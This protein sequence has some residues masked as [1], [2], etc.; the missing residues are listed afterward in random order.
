MT[1]AAAYFERKAPGYL[2]ACGRGLWGRL[3]AAE[4][5]AVRACLE[6]SPGL[7][8]LDAGC[9]PGYYSLRLREAGAEVRGMDLSPAML[10]E[11]RALDFEGE[12]A[13]LETFRSDARYDRILAAGVLEFVDDPATALRNLAGLLKDGG[14]LVCLIPAAGLP[15]AAYAAAHRLLGCPARVRVTGSYTALAAACGLRTAKTAKATPLS[16]ALAFRK[17]A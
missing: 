6:L 8:V 5:E 3:K 17:A 12:E 14:L 2:K 7:T 4:W 10:A 11:Y 13:S 1:T 16:L 9:G 15:G